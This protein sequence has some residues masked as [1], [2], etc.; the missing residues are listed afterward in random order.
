MPRGYSPAEVDYG[1]VLLFE[2]HIPA[3]FCYDVEIWL[4]TKILAKDNLLNMTLARFQ[5]PH[6][7]SFHD[8]MHIAASDNFVVLALN[9]PKHDRNITSKQKKDSVSLLRTVGHETDES[10]QCHHQPSRS[11]ETENS[12]HWLPRILIVSSR[13]RNEIA[14]Q[15][16]PC[17]HEVRA[18]GYK[19]VEGSSTSRSVL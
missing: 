18:L 4:P 14:T 1:P 11:H 12:F 2:L 6:G 19:A 10:V 7:F 16:L 8:P 9:S 15:C 13:R 3:S 5:P 17:H